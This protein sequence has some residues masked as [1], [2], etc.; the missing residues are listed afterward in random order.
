MPRMIS[1]IQTLPPCCAMSFVTSFLISAAIL[2][3]W[4]MPTILNRDRGFLKGGGLFLVL[5][6]LL[7]CRLAQQLHR[8]GCRG[9][10][11]GLFPCRALLAGAGAHDRPG[12]PLAFLAV[13]L[14]DV[15]DGLVGNGAEQ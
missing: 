3:P 6:R 10:K 14:V 8:G 2:S 1:P 7:A 5:V 11:V 4:S 12:Q 13:G 15:L 9:V